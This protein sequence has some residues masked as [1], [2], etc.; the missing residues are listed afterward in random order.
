MLSHLDF[1]LQPDII[2]AEYIFTTRALHRGRKDAFKVV[3]THDDFSTK[4]DKVVQF[5]VEDGLAM[6]SDE[7]AGLLAPA[8]LVIAIQ[9]EE[10]A[11]LRKLAPNKPIVRLASISTQPTRFRVAVLIL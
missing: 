7:E 6:T 5:G 11:E 1:A 10:A 4:H 8:D 2:L 3:D 9:S